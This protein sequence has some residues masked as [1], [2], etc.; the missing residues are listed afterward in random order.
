M[1]AVEQIGKETIVIIE[2]EGGRIKTIIPPSFSYSLGD[3]VYVLPQ[4]EAIYLF[5]AASG[6][7]LIA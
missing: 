3:S 5:D 4:P 6:E 2:Y 1:Y 7:S